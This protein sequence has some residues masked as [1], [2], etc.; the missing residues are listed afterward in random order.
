MWYDSTKPIYQS[1]HFL[2]IIDL[3]RTQ[4]TFSRSYVIRLLWVIYQIETTKLLMPEYSKPAISF[5][6][7]KTSISMNYTV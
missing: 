6:N 4:R 2:V 7:D 1:A 5:P 3:T